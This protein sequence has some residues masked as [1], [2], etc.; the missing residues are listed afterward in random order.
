MRCHMR[1]MEHAE[2]QQEDVLGILT[3]DLQVWPQ[4]GLQLAILTV[5]LPG[6]E[7]SS[8]LTE[9]GEGRPFL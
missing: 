5:W 4:Q 6:G 1:T 2:M 3:G 9:Y 7:R 8:I